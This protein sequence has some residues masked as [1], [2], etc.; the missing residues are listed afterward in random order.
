MKKKK[1]RGDLEMG[2]HLAGVDR[3]ALGVD[4]GGDHIGPLVHI[5]EQQSRA[6][7]GLRVKPGAPIAVPARPYFEVEGA[8]HSVLLRPKD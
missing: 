4:A 1:K 8:V 6:D 7:A 3:L 2:L 5:G